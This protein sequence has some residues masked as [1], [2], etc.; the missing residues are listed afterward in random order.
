M[1]VV[2]VGTGHVGLVTAATLA[3][4]GHTVVGLDQDEEK[5][6]QLRSGECP[7]FEPG[8]QELLDGQIAAQRLRFAVDASDGVPDAD[9]LFVCV[10]TPAKSTGEA[11]LVA[12]ERVARSVAEHITPSVAVVEKSTVP[13]GTAQ[14]LRQVLLRERPELHDGVDVIS[15]PEFLREGRAVEDSISPDRLLVGASSERGFATMRRLYEPL[16]RGGTR[17]I[18]TDIETA[19]LAKHACN[20]FLALKISYANALARMCELAGADVTDVAEVMGSDPRI[21]RAFLDAG[22]GYGGYCFPKDLQAFERLA[23]HLGYDFP[24][25]REVERLN[26]EA[27]SAALDKV[28][29]AVW[30]LEDKRIALLGLSFKPET[31]DVRFSP[32]LALARRLLDEGATVVGYDPYAEDNARAELAGLETASD[33]YQALEGAHCV[34]ICTA[35]EEFRTLDLDKAKEL[36]AYPIMVDGR[37]LFDPVQMVAKGFTYLGTGRS[38]NAGTT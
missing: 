5:I 27:V 31:D 12:I 14:R 36:L 21:G 30:N 19:E 29:E 7:F 2:V 4:L 35:W 1:R 6:G 20:A 34:V 22:L 33:V 13:A 8:L 37:N 24:L 11:N 17:L 15:N 32:A 9:V 26:E 28:R 18:E 25:L 10:G 38:T 16:I 23:D 3:G